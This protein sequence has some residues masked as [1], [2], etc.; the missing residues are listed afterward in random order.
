MMGCTIVLVSILKSYHLHQSAVL[1]F[2]FPFCAYL[3]AQFYAMFVV[4]LSLQPYESPIKNR[5]YLAKVLVYEVD[6]WLILEV[7]YFWFNMI[8]QMVFLAFSS[9][10]KY[11]SVWKEKYEKKIDL[12]EDAR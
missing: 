11:K 10:V 4:K 12:D 5:H 2:W 9:F 6:F 7:N 3:I 8:A 1:I